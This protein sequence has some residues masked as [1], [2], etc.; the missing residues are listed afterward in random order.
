MSNE[1]I[2]DFMH[3]NTVD[4]C[5]RF[6]NHTG[7]L[8]EISRVGRLAT[9]RLQTLHS[10]H[11]VLF[12]R[13][14][15]LYR[16]VVLSHGPR[17]ILYPLLLYVQKKA[18]H[19]LRVNPRLSEL[20]DIHVCKLRHGPRKSFVDPQQQDLGRSVIDHHGNAVKRMGRVILSVLYLAHF[21]G[22]RP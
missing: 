10:V 3:K 6:C 17:R 18:S 7:P 5:E 20:R 13:F 21:E 19:S 15:S 22:I 8:N 16:A 14:L 1:S 12:L 11:S 4:G 2:Q 9:L